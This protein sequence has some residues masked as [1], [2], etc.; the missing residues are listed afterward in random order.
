MSKT[1]PQPD[2]K[3]REQQYDN[4]VQ[5]P[6]ANENPVES[7]VQTTSFAKAVGVQSAAELL[8]EASNAGCED[9]VVTRDDD[10]ENPEEVPLH[11]REWVAAHAQGNSRST[12]DRGSI[13]WD[14]DP[15]EYP[16]SWPTHQIIEAVHTIGGDL[17]SMHGPAELP[18]ERAEA[19]QRAQAQQ[20]AG[21]DDAPAQRAGDESPYRGWTN[22]ELE[23]VESA[24]PTASDSEDPLDTVDQPSHGWPSDQRSQWVESAK[25]I[26]E[27]SRERQRAD[28]EAHAEDL[29]FQDTSVQSVPRNDVGVRPRPAYLAP[30]DGWTSRFPNCS[31]DDIWSAAEQLAEKWEPS[32]SAGIGLPA[33]P[34]VDDLADRIVTTMMIETK[35]KRGS[36]PRPAKVALDMQERGRRRATSDVEQSAGIPKTEKKDFLGRLSEE[37]Q[38]AVEEKAELLAEKWEPTWSDG[39]PFDPSPSLDKLASKLARLVVLDGMEPADAALALADAGRSRAENHII[40]GHPAWVQARKYEL[41]IDVHD[42]EVVAVFEPSH[43]RQAQCFLVRDEFNRTAKVTVWK[44][45][46]APDPEDWRHYKPAVSPATCDYVAEGDTVDLRDFRVRQYDGQ[47]ILESSRMDWRESTVDVHSGSR[48]KDVEIITGYT[49]VSGS[50]SQTHE[51]PSHPQ[52]EDNIINPE[53]GVRSNAFVEDVGWHQCLSWTYPITSETPEWFIEQHSEKVT[54]DDRE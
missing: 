9:E 39:S 46:D 36:A 49:N 30:R 11:E 43:T 8:S 10:L 29:R 44:G 31:A 53:A 38:E 54:G 28:W 7:S 26:T 47:T 14:N 41:T 21:L 37:T 3:A 35:L 2:R 40:G 27:E 42:V 15:T 48:N 4:L 32:W 24:E 34:T 6:E 33:S 20:P 12:R 25:A 17:G 1:N 13:T 51:A 45:H 23:A 52:I 19:R 18:R 50:A 22:D 16:A 5:T